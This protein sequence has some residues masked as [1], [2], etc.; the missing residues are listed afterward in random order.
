MNRHRKSAT[1]PHINSLYV[2]RDVTDVK[3]LKRFFPVEHLELGSMNE[4][5][6]AD[7]RSRVRITTCDAGQDLV[8]THLQPTGEPEELQAQVGLYFTDIPPTNV[9]RVFALSSLNIDLPPGTSAELIED[10][11][12]MPV[13]GDLLAV[14]PHTHYLGKRLQ[15]F[16]RAFGNLAFVFLDLGKLERPESCMRRAIELDPTDQLSN[17]TLVQIRALQNRSKTPSFSL[18]VL[19]FGA[20]FRQA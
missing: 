1:C 5:L 9:T 17:D 20:S 2:T 11:F 12:T 18:L 7:R 10:Q 8:Q 16:A 6:D 3:S 15:G 13:D 14:L 19:Y 4:T